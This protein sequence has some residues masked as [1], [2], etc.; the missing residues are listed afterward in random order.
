MEHQSSP[1]RDGSAAHIDEGAA[2]KACMAY[3]IT[4]RSK[5][6]RAMQANNEQWSGTSWARRFALVQ[7]EA[8]S[9]EAKKEAA[10]AR[11]SPLALFAL[12][13]RIIR[14]PDSDTC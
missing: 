10:L 3:D 7:A 8:A 2:E 1:S 6:S 4:I 9:F 14:S 11:C 13:Q 5:V 12:Q